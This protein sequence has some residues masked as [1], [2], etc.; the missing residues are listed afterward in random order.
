MTAASSDRSSYFSAIEKKYG[1]PIKFYL[2][3]LGNLGDA[4][5]A[6]Q[7]SLLR[8]NFGFSQ[9]HAN[10]LVMYARGSTSSR[11][12]ATPEDYFLS[13]G[14][15]REKTARAVFATI[16][17]KYPDLELVIAWN[18]PMLR[19][20]KDYIFGLMGAKNHLL[21]APWGGI[22]ET[23]LARLKGLKVN[24]KTV[25]IPVDWKIDAPLLR[26]MVKERLAQLGD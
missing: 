21:L 1:K 25:Q 13:L 10:A 7:I 16:L 20:G 19:R 4:K 23:I 3:A 8:E 5:Y 11:R 24:K 14:G 15:E 22:S 2:Q 6:E 26:L 17:S 9:T 18:Q 12:V